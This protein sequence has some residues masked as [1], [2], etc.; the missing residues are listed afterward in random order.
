MTIFDELRQM[1]YQEFCAQCPK[2]KQCHEDCTQCDIVLGW[3]EIIDD[4]EAMSKA[5]DSR[6]HWIWEKDDE[7]AGGGKTTCSKCKFSYSDEAY[8]H[9]SDFKYCPNCGR[10]MK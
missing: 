7:Y 3:N 1:N 4:L 2:E 10:K 6:A 9:V 5:K 8:F